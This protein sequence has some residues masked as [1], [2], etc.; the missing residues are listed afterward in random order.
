MRVK[1]ENEAFEIAQNASAQQS[2]IITR[3]TTESKA[4]R[5]HAQNEGLQVIYSALNITDEK[6]KNSLDYIRTLHSKQASMYV[7]FQY[8]VARP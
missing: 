2:L 4:I 5:E 1:I 7:G 8:M 3:A 6:H